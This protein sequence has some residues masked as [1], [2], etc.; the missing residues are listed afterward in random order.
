MSPRWRLNRS[1]SKVKMPFYYNHVHRICWKCQFFVRHPFALALWS[2]NTYHLARPHESAA[3]HFLFSFNL[4]SQELETLSGTSPGNLEYQR[5]LQEW[6]LLHEHNL[7][8]R[9][10]VS[11]V[12]KPSFL[13]RSDGTG[14]SSSPG[15]SSLGTEDVLITDTKSVFPGTKIL[16]FYIS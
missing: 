11:P 1:K 15:L 5:T 12:I 13:H 16:V 10:T 3:P 8:N 6:L 2:P 9:T 4:V 7:K 14:R